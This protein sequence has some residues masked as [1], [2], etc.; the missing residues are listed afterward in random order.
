M[1]WRDLLVILDPSIHRSTVLR[2]GPPPC[3]WK[4]SRDHPFFAQIRFTS[5]RRPS[6]VD[7]S[8]EKGFAEVGDAM[9]APGVLGTA[10][11][12]AA[13]ACQC[14]INGSNDVFGSTL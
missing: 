9:L 5:R 1:A 14:K 8:S 6:A 4:S 2:S 11:F 12:F 13:S 10:N 3:S 7:K